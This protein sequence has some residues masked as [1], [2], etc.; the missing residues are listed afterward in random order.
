MSAISTKVMPGSP[1]VSGYIH[2][3]PAGVALPTDATT[4]LA[5]GWTSLGLISN[6]GVKPEET[7]KVEDE[8]DWNEDVILTA[9][10]EATIKRSLTLVSTLEFEVNV[11][12]FG[13]ANV[14][15]VA[16]TATAGEQIA[17]SRDGA[18]IEPCQI[19]LDMAFGK[20]LH[21]EVFPI[22]KP[23]LTGRL[24]Y[25]KTKAK[26]FTLDLTAHKDSNGK[27]LYEYMTDGVT[28]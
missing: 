15:R 10:G 5:A 9:D 19:V 1:K 27:F 16:A 24:E 2:Y 18:G 6:D 26:G 21:R 12:L 22:M 17:I 3:S 25:K 14:T 13:S 4:D 7:T 20:K 23:T 8:R 28:A 11:F